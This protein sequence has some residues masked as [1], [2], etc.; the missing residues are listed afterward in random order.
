MFVRQS[1]AIENPHSLYKR[2]AHL[3]DMQLIAIILA[4]DLLLVNFQHV[5][6]RHFELEGKKLDV[7]F[8]QTL[9]QVIRL[10]SGGTQ[11]LDENNVRADL[12]NR[13]CL[14]D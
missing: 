14:W 4:S 8:G 6:I 3:L 10:G 12:L 11:M 5:A 13:G 2:L 9:R 1:P 7:S